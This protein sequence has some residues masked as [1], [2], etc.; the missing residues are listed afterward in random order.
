MDQVSLIPRSIT[1]AENQPGIVCS[2]KCEIIDV[3]HT[4]YYCRLQR[5]YAMKY[6]YVL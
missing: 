6:P 5:K 3:V 1:D 2:C 4:V